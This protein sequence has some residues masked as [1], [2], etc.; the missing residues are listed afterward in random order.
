VR[1]N[2]CSETCNKP[3]KIMTIGI[4]NKNGAISFRLKMETIFSFNKSK[5]T[6]VSKD[7]IKVI[8]SD[9]LIKPFA[10]LSLLGKTIAI[11]YVKAAIGIIIRVRE[12]NVPIIRKASGPYNLV[13]K[14]DKAIVTACAPAAPVAIINTFLTNDD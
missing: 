4:K 12:V 10:S 1:I 9:S 2:H 13:I 5:I 3:A 11:G 7:I 8:Y 14:G 6:V